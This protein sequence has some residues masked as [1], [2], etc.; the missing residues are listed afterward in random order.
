MWLTEIAS[1]ATAF[2]VFLLAY[3]IYLQRK[4]QRNQAI[5]RLFDELV[6]L[7]FRRQLLFIYSRKPEDLVVSKL[8]DSEREMV[9]DVTA[10]F[11]GLGF[12]VRK[13][14]IP[15]KESLELFWDLVVRSAQQLRPHIQ[16]Q[17][18]K[19]QEKQGAFRKY[20]EYKADF[21]WL[22]RECKLFHL[23][24]VGQK[25]SQKDISLDELLQLEPLPI[26]TAHTSS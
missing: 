22:A 9:E 21:D 23:Q 10:R 11:D 17:R 7:E 20:R 5:A 25:I 8:T 19:R 24:G 13:R 15:K 14:I 26:F 16:D 18:D 4:D 3:Q 2:A 6:T 12:R 1:L